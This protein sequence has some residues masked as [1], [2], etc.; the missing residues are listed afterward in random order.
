VGVAVTFDGSGSIDPDGDV[1]TYAWDFGDGGTGTGVAPTH[2][3]AAA[4][5]PGGYIVTLTVT[6]NGLTG[7]DTS[8]ATITTE[9]PAN[10]FATGGNKTIGLASGKPYSC[11]QIEPSSN[12]F[13]TSDVDLTSIKMVSI[14]TGSVSEISA[15]ASKTSIDGDK[16]GNGITEITACFRKS[17]LRLLFSTVPSGPHPITVDIT[18]TLIT[19]GSF[20]GS[21]TLTVKGT[22]GV[23]AANI[24][25]NPLN[26][27][28][29][30]SFATTK[31]GAIRVQMFDPQ[32]RLVKTIADERSSLAG[33]HD[34]TIDGRSNT[35]SK[36][37]SGVYFVKVWSEFDGIEVKSIT[38]LK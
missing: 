11:V 34:Y 30:L 16:N 13:I 4:S 17:D 18:G 14:G 5:P 10:V 24:S 3:Y 19:G 6:A 33:Y 31:P 38:V 20:R 1:L 21:I 32:G 12:S 29:K 28:A 26:P 8:T 35:G 25:P 7:T 37:A 22:G 2:A 15:D 27:R 36:L 9:F 23:L